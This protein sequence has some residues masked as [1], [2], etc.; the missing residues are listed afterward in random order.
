MLLYFIFNFS[1]ITF[2]RV[3]LTY[4]K[5]SH[6][7]KTEFHGLIAKCHIHKDDTIESVNCMVGKLI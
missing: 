7:G 3:I 6:D 4:G 1:K 5:F 2:M